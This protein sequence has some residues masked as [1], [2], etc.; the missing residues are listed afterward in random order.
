MGIEQLVFA[1]LQQLSEAQCHAVLKYMD[2]LVVT[3]SRRCF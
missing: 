1:K 3:K 2:Y